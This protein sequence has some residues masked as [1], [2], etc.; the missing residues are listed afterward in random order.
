MVSPS[1][2]PFCS[3]PALSRAVYS[4]APTGFRLVLA[5]DAQDFFDRGFAAQDLVETV[6]ANGR[7]HRAR[8]TLEVVFGGFVVNHGPHRIVDDDELVDAGAPAEP[9]GSRTRPVDRRGRIVGTQ[10]E[11]PALVFSGHEG[12]FGFRIERAH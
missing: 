11:E 1:T 10:T 7:C 9:A 2:T 8:I 3:R 4:K 6:V 12:L 5:R